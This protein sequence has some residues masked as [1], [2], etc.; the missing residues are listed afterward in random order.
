MRFDLADACHIFYWNFDAQLE[1]LSRSSVDNRYGPE[2]DC[3]AFGGLVFDSGGQ[4]LCGLLFAFLSRLVLLISCGIGSAEESGYL[5]EGTLGC[6]EA[7][8][9]YLPAS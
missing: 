9:L 4:D 8:A 1:C 7:D 2:P 6:R 5:F 3:I